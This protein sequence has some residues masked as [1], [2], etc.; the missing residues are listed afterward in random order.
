MKYPGGAINCARHLQ[1]KHF[2]ENN[3]NETRRNEYPRTYYTV[4]FSKTK[5]VGQVVFVVFSLYVTQKKVAIILKT[6]QV[7]FPCRQV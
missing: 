1:H 5:K 7:F 4:G 3:P 6:F 2:R